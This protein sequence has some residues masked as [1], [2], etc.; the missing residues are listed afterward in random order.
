VEG[1][2]DARPRLGEELLLPGRLTPYRGYVVPHDLCTTALVGVVNQAWVKDQPR[3]DQEC[4]HPADA[5]PGVSRTPVRS[6]ASAEVGEAG[7]DQEEHSRREERQPQM[8][9]GPRQAPP[10]PGED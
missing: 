10:K 9:T 3:G 7:R 5:E 6:H 1:I 8:A 2:I 4:A